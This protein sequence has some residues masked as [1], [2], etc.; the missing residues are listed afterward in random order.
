[1]LDAIG[2]ECAGAI[3]VYPEGKNPRDNKQADVLILD[4]QEAID[5]LASLEARP[6]LVGQ[7]DIRISG[8]GAQNK[9]M[10]AFVGEK[11]AIPKG[12]TPSTHIIKP[13]IKG[14]EFLHSELSKPKTILDG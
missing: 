12:H 8:A 2:G 13:A 1:M 14:F 7:D 5:V 11:I 3:S 6:F 10:I 9:L 4:D